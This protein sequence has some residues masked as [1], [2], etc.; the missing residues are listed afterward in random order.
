MCRVVGWVR[1]VGDLCNVAC[2]FDGLREERPAARTGGCQGETVQ[3][4]AISVHKRASPPTSMTQCFFRACLE[5]CSDDPLFDPLVAQKGFPVQVLGFLET[6]S[7]E[8]KRLAACRS[9]TR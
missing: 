5:C 8:A 1:P 7:V 6:K 2:N 4:A 9:F 3:S